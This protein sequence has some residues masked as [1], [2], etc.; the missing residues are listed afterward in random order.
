[1]E[2]R[3]AY[4]AVAAL[5]AV[6]L[7]P[8]IA[9]LIDGG[10]LSTASTIVL[11][12]ALLVACVAILEVG[13]FLRPKADRERDYM[14]MMKAR[15]QAYDAHLDV[16]QDGEWSN[17]VPPGAFAS[18]NDRLLTRSEVRSEIA[19]TEAQPSE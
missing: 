2:S 8:D 19:A 5:L 1:V 17:E 13:F 10:R 16:G 11:W 18:E 14:L 9:L 3:W 6:V 15:L 12:I 7:P 4:I